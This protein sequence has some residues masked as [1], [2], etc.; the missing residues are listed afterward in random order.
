MY[1]GVDLMTLRRR[2][3]YS[4]VSFIM[5]KIFSRDRPQDM[6][7]R[8]LTRSRHLMRD[9]LGLSEGNYTLFTPCSNSEM[10]CVA[11]NAMVC[12]HYFVNHEVMNEVRYDTS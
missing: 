3:K 7:V 8:L 2:G 1:S 5:R 6:V 9:A 12:Y 4:S 10:T 11:N